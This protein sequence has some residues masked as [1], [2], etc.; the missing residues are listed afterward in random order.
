VRGHITGGEM[1]VRVAFII[2]YNRWARVVRLLGHPRHSAAL[3]AV[4]DHMGS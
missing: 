2:P 4:A 3:S 1:G